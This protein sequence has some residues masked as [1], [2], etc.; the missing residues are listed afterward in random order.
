MMPSRLPLFLSAGLLAQGLF[1]VLAGCAATPPRNGVYSLQPHQ[2]ARLA[3]GS[4][5]TYDSY[6]D[7][8]CPAEVRCIWSGRLVLRFIVDSPGGRAEFTLA[9]DQPSATLAVLHGARIALDPDTIPPVRAS[10]TVDDL[11]PVTLTVTQ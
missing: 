4:T 1:A 9:P 11:M 3:D 7:S 8:R 10:D 5:L 6:S 2:R